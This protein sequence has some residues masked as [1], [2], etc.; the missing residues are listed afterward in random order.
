MELQAWGMIQI[1]MYP[2]WGTSHTTDFQLYSH[3][4]QIPVPS[5]YLCNIV[6]RPL[7]CFLSSVVC[8]MHDF[9]IFPRIHLSLILHFFYSIISVLSLNY[10]DFFLFLDQER[11]ARSN[12]TTKVF[13]FL[14]SWQTFIKRQEI[15]FNNKNP[16][17]VCYYKLRLS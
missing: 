13:I 11:I 14:S 2:S 12:M 8:I 17:I 15:W 9:T 6:S 10:F 4:Y 16:L 7:S 1:S 3:L 5:Q